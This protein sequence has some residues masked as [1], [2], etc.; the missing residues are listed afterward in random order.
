MPS[1]ERKRQGPFEI[2]VPSI[3]QSKHTPTT[4]MRPSKAINFLEEK[5]NPPKIL[6]RFCLTL[7]LLCVK[8]LFVMIMPV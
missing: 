2:P 6:I 1:H 7:S 4:Q 8:K 3:N 5:L